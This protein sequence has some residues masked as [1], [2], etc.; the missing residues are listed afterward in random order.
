MIFLKCKSCFVITFI[1]SISFVSAASAQTVT[2]KWYGIGNVDIPGSTNDYM[3]EFIIKQTGNSVTG[4]MNYFFRDGYFSNRVTGTYN[5]R[6]RE[7]KLKP[8]PILYHRS[9]NPGT[10]VDCIMTGVFTL[11]V[12]K[13]ESTLSGSFLSDAL[14]AYTAPPID[15][16]FRKLLKNE[17]ELK[18]RIAQKPLQLEATTVPIETASKAIPEAPKPTFQI[19]AEKEVK[20][21]AKNI[22]RILDVSDDSVRIDL[23]DNADLDYDSVSVFYNNK[24][25]EYKQMLDTKKP[26][27]FYVPVDSI[28]TNN[29]LVMFAENL[30]TIPPNSALMIIS[31]KGHRYEIPLTSTYQK[32]A[33]VRL[34]KVQAVTGVMK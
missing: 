8:V 24:L 7:M 6:T 27:Q 11:K 9:V 2:G 23:Y 26:I 25:V 29:D 17:P 31:D 5:P 12:S 34:R 18:E 20:M 19:K 30:G 22:V 4:F 15:V 13:A 10:G 1:L 14:H 28:E 3:M 33:A 16:K 32:N 21:R